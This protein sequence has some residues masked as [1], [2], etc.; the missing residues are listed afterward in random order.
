MQQIFPAAELSRLRSLS[1]WEKRLRAK[2]FLRIAGVDEAGR[3]PLA[4]PVVAAACMLHEKSLFQHL[5]DSKQLT[6]EQRNKLFA[7]ITAD[8]RV[9]YG[10]G[11]SDVSTIDRVNILQATFLA[12]QS[13]VAALPVEP[14][15]LLID[16]NR[17]PGFLYP[18]EAIVEGDA[19]S[20]SIAA[21]SILAKVTRDRM[22]VELDKQWP[23]Y[24]FK[25]HK[26]YGTEE[27]L[28]AIR[29]FGPCPIHRKSFEPIKSLL[30]RRRDFLL[31]VN[32]EAPISQSD[33]LSP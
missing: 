7:Q 32:A 20:I 19:R 3:G 17:L 12:M 18:A 11:M 21:A 27:H 8:Q 22:M 25:R 10:I 26:G 23:E 4:G 1:I 30:N 6:Q 33:P 31:E 28:E 9:V 15:Y 16:G 5:N 13:A 29:K 2:G 14:D 24:G